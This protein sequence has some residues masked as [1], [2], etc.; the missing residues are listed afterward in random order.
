M[1]RGIPVWGL[2]QIH[3]DMRV[4]G[5]WCVQAVET[6]ACQFPILV[7][8]QGVRPP[9]PGFCIINHTRA[10][11]VQSASPPSVSFHLNIHFLFVFSVLGCPRGNWKYLGFSYSFFSLYFPGG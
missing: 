1:F 6:V 3:G 9:Q 10:N 11:E 2:A 5:V 4:C 7:Y 8:K